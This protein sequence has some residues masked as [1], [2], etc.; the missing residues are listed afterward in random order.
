MAEGRTSG[1]LGSVARIVETVLATVQNRLE[2]FAVE[3][4]EEKGHLIQLLILA[5]V[6]VIL[7]LMALILL[8][9][10]IIA[11]F[12]ESGRM[13]AVLTLLLIYLTGAIAAG[14]VLQL[15]LKRWQA[16]AATLNE[17]KKD[18]ACLSNWRN[19]KPGNKPS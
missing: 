19:S 15:R 8:T 4:K 14:R 16:F 12:W 10:A 11:W 7:G 9:F 2:L 6:V 13:A 3:L 18:R 5:V 1:I 17:L